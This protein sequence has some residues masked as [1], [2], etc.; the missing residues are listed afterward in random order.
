MLVA[1]P[2]VSRLVLPVLL[3][4]V[5]T[6][7]TL[8]LGPLL[9][10]WHLFMNPREM[11]VTVV[12][13]DTTDA[14]MEDSMDALADALER[15]ENPA[16]QLA[17]ADTEVQ[18][19]PDTP[20]LSESTPV[21]VEQHSSKYDIWSKDQLIELVVTDRLAGEAVEYGL[22]QIQEVRMTSG[23]Q[24]T[25]KRVEGPGFVNPNLLEETEEVSRSYTDDSSDDGI[26][27]HY[28]SHPDTSLRLTLQVE[29]PS[30]SGSI[31][32]IRGSVLVRYPDPGLLKRIAIPELPPVGVTA[33]VHPEL[34]A[35]GSFK[36][37]V[38]EESDGVQI[39]Y[40]TESG[41]PVEFY[42]YDGSNT[43]SSQYSYGSAS[44]G[45]PVYRHITFDAEQI[46]GGGI[47]LV[48]PG[49]LLEGRIHFEA[50]DIPVN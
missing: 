43:R 6:L 35:L 44:M 42:L 18:V 29:H 24:L 10:S 31:E 9:D 37:I 17:L 45:G 41:D 1:R 38:F 16:S 12:D 46:K 50:F 32:V 49:P 13:D 8:R 14:G 5:V 40:I 27:K 30:K 26:L 33:L 28:R 4:V 7:F 34:D 15:Y 22:V 39:D 36:L 25:V 11:K 19:E 47:E 23:E 21:R 3:A 2:D 48:T 20:L